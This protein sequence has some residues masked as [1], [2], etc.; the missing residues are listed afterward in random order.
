MRGKKQT[1]DRHASGS[2]PQTE[3][4]RDLERVR[5]SASLSVDWL[6]LL[7]SSAPVV[8]SWAPSDEIC[9]NLKCLLSSS[10]RLEKDL[11]LQNRGASTSRTFVWAWRGRPIIDMAARGSRIDSRLGTSPAPVKHKTTHCKNRKIE[12]RMRK[13]ALLGRETGDRNNAWALSFVLYL[14]L[15]PFDDIRQVP[16]IGRLN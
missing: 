1:T 11:P 14:P 15:V 6:S 4:A 10:M 8:S 12:G 7:A 16:C 5:T 2:W 9:S 3:D 13:V